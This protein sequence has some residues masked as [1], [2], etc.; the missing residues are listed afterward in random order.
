MA[1]A[2]RLKFGPGV[3]HVLNRGIND[4]WILA[5]PE[6]KSCLVGIWAKLLPTLRLR[7]HHWVV[8]SNHFHLAVDAEDIGELS[9]FVGKA[10]ALYSRAWHRRK[11][12]HGPLWQARYRSI[13]VQKQ[14]YFERL[15][16]YIERNPVVAMDAGVALPEEYP[17][18]S[19]AAYVLGRP[20]P[21]VCREL[22]PHWPGWGKDDA[23]RVGHY[24]KLLHRD[25]V[26]DTM[27]FNQ[28]N[29]NGVVGSE[30][31]RV[32]AWRRQGRMS[33]QKPGARKGKR[34]D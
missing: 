27:L 11:G 22:H 10:C 21:L 8:M 4:A 14:I 15:G 17:W 18:S 30:E 23:A 12:G 19:A 34:I 24:R 31:F 20:D 25:D 2:L 28:N 7:V 29:G 33:D 9:M 6:E 16:R 26:D 32:N 1:R 13:L 3:Y 5:T